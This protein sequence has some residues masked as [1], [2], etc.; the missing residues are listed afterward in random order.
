[1]NTLKEINGRYYQ[2]AEIIMLAT[3]YGKITLYDYDNLKTLSLAQGNHKGTENTIRPQHLYIL[4]NEEIKEGDWYY[5]K[6]FDSIYQATYLPL[7]IK[8]SKKIIATTDKSI[9]Y[10][11]IRVSPVKNF[12]TYPQPSDSFIKKYIEEYNAGRTILKVLV[13]YEKVYPKHFT[14]NPSENIIINLKVDSN[15][16][17]TI[18]RVEPKVYTEKDLSIFKTLNDD[19]FLKFIYNRLHHV[20]K[21]DEN[22]DYMHKLKSIVD[23]V[24]DKLNLK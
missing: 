7:A 8:D 1:M 20:H 10:T 2:E 4:S 24:D 15:N 19:N 23:W 12:C 11:D 22:L 5:S 17:T 9:G 16:T 14:Y 21:E 6:T 3:K 18:K 13:E